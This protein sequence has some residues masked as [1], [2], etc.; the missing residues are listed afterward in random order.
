MTSTL[1]RKPSNLVI[2]L[3]EQTIAFEDA[4]HF[5]ENGRE[6]VDRKMHDFSLHFRVCFLSGY[7]C[8]GTAELQIPFFLSST[9]LG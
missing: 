6:I 5:D 7:L 4:G 1:V 3:L 2:F 9:R 8:L